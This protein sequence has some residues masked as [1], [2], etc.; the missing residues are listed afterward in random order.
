[1]K[2]VVVDLCGTLILEN[3]THGYLASLPL[4]PYFA[5]RNRLLR[6]RLGQVINRMAGRD[7]AREQLILSL[8]GWSREALAESAQSY[9]RIAIA[10]KVSEPVR[11]ALLAARSSGAKIYLATSSLQPIAE[12]VVQAFSLDGYIATALEFEDSGRCTGRILAD[13]T[14][15]KWRVICQ[16][17][18]DVQSAEITVYTDNPED[19]DLKQV[20]ATFH[21]LG[22]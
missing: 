11:D 8:R 2:A 20:A 10:Q 17:Y 15:N 6:S 5:I 21:Y 18:P 13:V 4:S 19:T 9:V 22:S 1:M 7:I 12:A 16:R 3:T 14:G